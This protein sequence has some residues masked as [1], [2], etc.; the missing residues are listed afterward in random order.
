MRINKT[1][2]VKPRFQQTLRH[3]LGQALLFGL[4]W[5]QFLPRHVQ[6][7]DQ[8]SPVTPRVQN[9]RIHRARQVLSLIFLP[10]GL[11]IVKGVFC[12]VGVRLFG[13]V[14]V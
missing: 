2:P 7:F 1:A 5:I 3:L 11:K 8:F 4:L 13:A 10:F 9:G 12:D 14:E 6:S